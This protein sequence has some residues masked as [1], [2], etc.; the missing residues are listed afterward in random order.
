VARPWIGSSARAAL[1][2]PVRRAVRRDG[3]ARDAGTADYVGVLR[4]DV[5]A[6]HARISLAR[7][8]FCAVA[9][10]A[11]GSAASAQLPIARARPGLELATRV[12]KIVAGGGADKADAR[13][14]LVPADDLSPGDELVITV[15][16]LNTTQH[17]LDG[18][19]IT[20]PIPPSMRYVEGSGVGPGSAVLYSVD[21]GATYGQPNELGV[22]TAE[23]IRRAAT[24]DDYTHV[25]WLIKAPLAAGARAFVRFRATVRALPETAA[26]A[27]AD[28]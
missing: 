15:T 28:P 21:G 23:G 8:I 27:H 10:C 4:R 9:I 22:V 13:T 20:Q 6:R 17:A 11:V 5:R 26:D 2:G 24:A 12:E 18:V 7:R 25:R 1:G 3:G 16:F 19:R 14:K